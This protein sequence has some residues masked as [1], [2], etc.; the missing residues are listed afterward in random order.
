MSETDQPKPRQHCSGY[1]VVTNPPRIEGY[2]TVAQDQQQVHAIG[3]IQE[4]ST[5]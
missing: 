3:T 4:R 2:A 5:Q 1:G